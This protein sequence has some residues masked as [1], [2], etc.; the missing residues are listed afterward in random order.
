MPWF[1]F[2]DY[3]AL[4]TLPPLSY[5][6][7]TSPSYSNSP[8]I[9]TFIHRLPTGGLSLLALWPLLPK[10]CQ[11]VCILGICT[12][13]HTH[14]SCFLHE[15][16]LASFSSPLLSPGANLLSELSQHLCVCLLWLRSYFAGTFH[17]LVYKSYLL[18]QT[19]SAS[20][21]QL[22]MI[23]FFLPNSNWPIVGIYEWINGQ[24]ASKA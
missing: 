7:S 19:E 5:L 6:N 1:P 24:L 20:R 23:H 18:F 12:H 17:L 4:P 3:S 16:F 14:G 8:L 22:F 9:C 21:N 15:D 2:L 13:I 10:V 11:H